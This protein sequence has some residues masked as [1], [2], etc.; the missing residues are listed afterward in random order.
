MGYVI[1]QEETIQFL[2]SQ[3]H[4]INISYLSSVG[5]VK[6]EAT[7]AQWGGVKALH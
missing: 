3:H 2:F 4:S 5:S 7:I 1:I 6:E